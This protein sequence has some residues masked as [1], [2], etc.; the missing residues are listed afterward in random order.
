MYTKKR[1][2]VEKK[3]GK[4][5]EK[6]TGKKRAKEE[7]RELEERIT[8]KE[9]E[10]RRKKPEAV[11]TNMRTRNSHFLQEK[12]E[13]RLCSQIMPTIPHCE[14]TSMIVRGLAKMKSKRKKGKQGH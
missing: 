3:R 10:R 9:G 13:H 4:E 2:H 1:R 12:A 7:E 8:K 5:K 14:K 6:D 11:K